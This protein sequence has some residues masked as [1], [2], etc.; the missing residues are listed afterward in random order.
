MN[1]NVERWCNDTEVLE[2]KTVQIQLYP[3]HFPREIN[4]DRTRSSLVRGRRLT[5]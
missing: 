4:W 2:E 5:V 3:P 1:T